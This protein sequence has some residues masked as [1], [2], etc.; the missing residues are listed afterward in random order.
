MIGSGQV[1]VDHLGKCDGD[2]IACNTSS[3]AL[4]I[5]ASDVSRPKLNPIDSQHSPASKPIALR[6]HDGSGMPGVQAGPSMPRPRAEGF[7]EYP[8]RHN[9]RNA[10][11]R[12][13]VP[14]IGPRQGSPSAAEVQHA[15]HDLWHRFASIAVMRGENIL[16]VGRPLGHNDP[17]T[18]LKYTHLAHD[19]VAEAA[20]TVGSVLG[21]SAA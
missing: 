14:F 21:G 17:G 2:S 7:G 6:T 15:S 1:A 16:T 11:S 9:Q 20:E 12:F 10:G 19:V 13:L 4:S 3:V 8:R 18:T 5:S